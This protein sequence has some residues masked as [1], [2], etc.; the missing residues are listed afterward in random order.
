MCGYVPRRKGRT[1]AAP[2]ASQARLGGGCDLL[3]D[4]RSGADDALPD[5]SRGA[6]VGAGRAIAEINIGVI[7]IFAVSVDIDNLGVVVVDFS[8][9]FRIGVS[10]GVL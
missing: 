4:R 6:V 7:R 10:I 5:I 1:D 8:V 9:L 3:K 2:G